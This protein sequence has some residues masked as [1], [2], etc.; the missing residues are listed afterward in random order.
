M[1]LS[2]GR[3]DTAAY[4][5]VR[6]TGTDAGSIISG[7]LYLSSA[8]ANVTLLN[9]IAVNER[10]TTGTGRALGLYLIAAP[11]GLLTNYNDLY[12]PA[13]TGSHVAAVG[14]TNY[15]TLAQ[16]QA[17][18]RDSQSVSVMPNFQA[19]H[20]HIN[21]TIPT[22]LDG[23]AKRIA[24]ITTDIDGQTRHPLRPDIGADEFAPASF[25]D[26]FEA[27]NVGQQLACQNPVDWTT[28][29]L[30]PCNATE[31]PF[32][33]SAFAYSGTK[34]V[35]IVQ[36]NDLVKRVTADTTGV[37]SMTFRFYIPR[38]KAGYFNTLAV[39][40][41]PST[42]NWG[43]E[44]Y[45]DST[46]NGRLFAGSATAF[47]FTFT[48]DAWQLARVVVDLTR[49]SAKFYINSTLVRT[50][51]WTA[52][53]SGGGSPRRLAAN[54][55]YGATAWDQMYMDDY[56]F[57]P[58]TWTGVEETPVAVPET[59]SLMQNYPNP[60]N[61]TTTIRYALPKEAQVRVQVYNILGQLV[62]EL[63]NDVQN[64]GYH[65]IVWNGRNQY[66]TQVATGVYLY[67]LEARPTDG[68]APFVST[69]K[70]LLVK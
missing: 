12:V 29:S 43:M 20:L 37:Y 40:T 17:T 52:G 42:F 2:T 13:Q 47:P 8:A 3:N 32:I 62:A 70:M 26:N 44:V 56:D 11:T 16:W 50:W 59:F 67:R 41:P 30:S 36:N 55:F 6:L 24:S 35:V 4:N 68:S 39:F 38:T 23:G 65:N 58:D 57:R 54:D 15:T 33:S 46:G 64:A 5:T 48:R 34:S 27:Y 45:F 51:R 66:G 63:V 10:V 19:P 7:A 14:T 53:A 18:G 61:P 22:V 25:F 9:N 60:F 28:W 31:D 21:P 69:K 1:Y 49:D